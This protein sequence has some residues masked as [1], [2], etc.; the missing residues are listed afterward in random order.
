MYYGPLLLPQHTCTDMPAKWAEGPTA[1]GGEL[2]PVLMV[3][4]HHLYSNSVF[5]VSFDHITDIN[6]NKVKD[7]LNVTPIH[8][9]EGITGV[10]ILPVVGDHIALTRIYR[11]PLEKWALESPKG[12]VDQG[13]TPQTA[14]A[15]ELQE[16]SGFAVPEGQLIHLGCAVP[17]GGVIKG[18]IELY[19]ANI[20][21]QTPIMPT[22]DDIGQEEELQ[23]IPVSAIPDH[24]QQGK[25]TDA[26]TLA[27]LYHLHLRTQMQ[28][29]Q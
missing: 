10:A 26:V 14:A 27:L 22:Q 13:E 4:I 1:R 11:Y 21:P 29:G 16:E 18:N 20:D 3:S 2:P 8:S 7:Y 23:F 24:V 9:H 15:R 12:F 28:G 17:E 25:I 5:N 6:G 19:L